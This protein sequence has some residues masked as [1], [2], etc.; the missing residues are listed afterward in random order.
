MAHR[1]P[2]SN[3]TTPPDPSSPP[4]GP[5]GRAPQRAPRGGDRKIPPRAAGAPATAPHEPLVVDVANLPSPSLEE[6]AAASA[7]RDPARSDE[8]RTASS[9]GPTPQN[10]PDGPIAGYARR[11]ATSADGARPSGALVAPPAGSPAV[12]LADDYVEAAD[13]GLIAGAVEILNTARDLIG[14]LMGSSGRGGRPWYE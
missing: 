8:R 10:T 7:E 2:M 4:D 9:L 13:G 5:R 11:I 1:R 14:T 3:T 12:P 6:G